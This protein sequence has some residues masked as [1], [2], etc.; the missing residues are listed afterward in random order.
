MRM[1]IYYIVQAELTHIAI[2]WT[3]LAEIA[4][5]LPIVDTSLRIIALAVE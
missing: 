2:I 5:Y 4:V 3:E 1:T